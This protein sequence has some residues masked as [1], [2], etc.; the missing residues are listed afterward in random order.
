[1]YIDYTDEQASL[2]A[3]LR[4]YFAK[5]LADSGPEPIERIARRERYRGILRRLGADGWL[6]IGWPV[7]YGGR[8]RPILEQFVFFDEAQRAGVPVPTIALNTVG[9]TLM[10]FGSEDQKARFLPRILTGEIDFSI[11]YTEPES[12]TDLASLRTRAVRDGDSYVINGNKVYTTGGDISDYIWLAA[13]TDADAP[14][15]KGISILIVD[16]TSPG[17]SVTTIHTVMNRSRPTTATYYSDVVVPAANLVAGENEGWKL[18]TTQLNHERVAMAAYGGSILQLLADVREWAAAEDGAGRRVLDQGWA[19]LALARAEA[20]LEAMRLIN[21]RMAAEVGREQLRPGDASAAKIFGTEASI[22]AV[23]L[24]LDVV[25]QAG[26]LQRGSQ[27]AVLQG[28]LEEAYRNVVVGTF[29]GGNNDI[30]REI[31]A[32]AGLGMPRARR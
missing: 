31:V 32:T 3:E 22:E 12:G 14:K 21:W 17:F 28:R 2:S 30:Q 16:T 29:G 9:P 25:G 24:M 19:A 1:M 18:I 6:G 13:R 26:V 20:R 4:T 23:R 8:G 5:L 11:G 27:G 15:H 10:R 7:E